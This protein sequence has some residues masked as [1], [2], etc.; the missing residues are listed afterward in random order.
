MNTFLNSSLN[1]SVPIL[2][3]AIALLVAGSIAIFVLDPR[4]KR[5]AFTMGVG[6]LAVFMTVMPIQDYEDLVPI[7]EEVLPLLYFDDEIM[8]DENATGSEEADAGTT[9]GDAA[10][11]L[12]Q[13]SPNELA[14]VHPVEAID[15]SNRNFV[16]AGLFPVILDRTANNEAGTAA[17]D[18]LL[19]RVQ[20]EERIPVMVSV[21]VPNSNGLPKLS[22]R[23]HDATT[24]RTWN[25]SSLGR[26]QHTENGYQVNYATSIPPG[27]SSND[28][29]AHLYVR[30]EA[31]GYV[32][33]EVDEKVT[34]IST[35]VTLNVD[36]KPTQTP[37]LIQRLNRPYKF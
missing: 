11:V 15:T 26:A 8:G 14:T 7:V 32:I 35:R 5:A 9:P 2:Y 25:I 34:N 6:I 1:L 23:L 28:V 12:P 29:L 13:L 18:K 24:D 37:L 33:T 4:T 17:F 31:S 36:L 16:R 10:F 30:V 27:R 21:S 3:Q 22:A 19:T 20:D